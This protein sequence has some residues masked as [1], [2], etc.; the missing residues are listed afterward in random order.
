MSK[1]LTYCVE[2]KRFREHQQQQDL[3][4]I[5]SAGGGY[6]HEILHVGVL[7]K[8]GSLSWL[9]ICSP[10]ANICIQALISQTD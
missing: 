1:I 2:G 7:Y 10:L 4:C 3:A 6:A 8:S 9:M 5:D